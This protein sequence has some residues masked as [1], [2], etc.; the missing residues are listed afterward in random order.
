MEDLDLDP[1]GGSSRFCIF[2][3]V[4]S[5]VVAVGRIDENRHTC[6]SGHHFAQQPE[7]LCSQLGHER[8]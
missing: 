8:N 6:R 7:P 2:R 4:N 3:T 5:E 1:K